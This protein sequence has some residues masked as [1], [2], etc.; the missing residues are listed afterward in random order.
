MGIG[1]HDL[2]AHIEREGGYALEMHM[3]VDATLTLGAA[4]A[5]VDEFERRAL[6]ARPDIRSIIT[7]IEPLPSA[8]PDETGDIERS[9]TLRQEIIAVANELA[10]AGACHNVEL[11][12][13]DG[14]LTATLHLTQPAN[15][16]LIQ[17]H[18]LAERIE[19]ELHTREAW[20]HRVVVHVEP[21]E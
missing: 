13:I 10:G 6:A 2:H 7:H 17:A 4:H 16:P 9:A 18:A 8:L 5:L 11:H 20:L 14:H 19:S 12:H 1:V 3:E 21:P 15:E